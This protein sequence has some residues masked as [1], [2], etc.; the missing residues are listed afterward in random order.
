[1]I[2]IESITKSFGGQDVFKDLSFNINKGEKIGLVGRNGNG[3]TTLFKMIIGEVEKDSGE[4][5]IPKNYKIGYL[6]QH[7]LFSKKTVLDEA[8]LG[9][10]EDNKY[11]T[12]KAEK[13]LSGLGFSEEDLEKD[14][15]VFSG[16]YQLR[17][18]LAKV[19]LSEPDLLLLDEPNNYLD[20][21]AIRWL[22]NFLKSWQGEIMLITHDRSFM[23]NIITHTVCIHR[24][25]AKKIE[26]TTEKL[27]EQ[28]ELEEE[29]YEKTRIN[30]EKKRKETEM[31][32]EKF[33]AKA[34]LAKS[35][36]SRIKSLEKMEVK[37]KL[38]KIDSLHFSFRYT[39][40]NANQMLK[41][42]NLYFGYEKDKEK[43]IKDF[44]IIIEKNDRI[45]IIGKNGKGKSILLKLLAEILDKDSGTI[46]KHPNMKLGYF[47]QTNLKN[48]NEENQIVE[49][50]LSVDPDNS[51]QKSRGVA[52]N[53]MFSG[54]LATKK[55]KVLSGGEKNRVMLGKILLS[56][57]NILFLDE[58]TNHLDMDSN[59]AL[60]HAINNFPG[61]VVIVTHN[62][63]YLMNF[64]K[65]L[66]V[67]DNDKISVYNDT[68]SDFLER[69]GWSSEIEENSLN[70]K[71]DK[72][73]IDKKDKEFHKKAKA[74]LIQEKSKLLKPI[75]DEIKNIEVSIEKLDE[76]M[77]FLNEEL[78]SAS[79]KS[80][81][82]GDLIKD[83][84]I[85]L[86]EIKKQID[87]KYEKLD[88]FY[89]EKEE[90][91]KKFSN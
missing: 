68:Y 73:K 44:S 18:N 32:I 70:V 31:F 37:E 26:G 63:N 86:K 17:L 69:I 91:E 88:K 50:L 6:Q 16:G 87:E 9:L 34:T 29:I 71:K 11:E 1:M 79:M 62:E 47:G 46:Y 3:K 56:P 65:K 78:L 36:Q 66:I 60:L 52:G 76:E 12:W 67:F 13:I 2:R 61:A 25:K 74:N 7:I 5:V 14:P 15:S 24:Q 51:I 38:E 49:E 84:S 23:D 82:N 85:K 89:E 30:E 19:L 4:I 8:V 40:F 45:A 58:P 43:I 20:I 35:V 57:C 33:R 54:D 75:N 39:D 55:I 72:K 21:V 42:E 53:L 28:I 10:S 59:E 83:L 64:A 41:A 27:Y 22:E 81:S 80:K 90:I 77:T 48:L